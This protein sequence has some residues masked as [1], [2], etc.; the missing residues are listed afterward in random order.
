MM[1]SGV[2]TTIIDVGAK[3]NR[4]LAHINNAIEAIEAIKNTDTDTF[5]DRDELIHDVNLSFGDLDDTRKN[6]IKDNPD[7]VKQYENILRD[8]D[9]VITIHSK[10]TNAMATLKKGKQA[11]EIYNLA[12]G[13]LNVLQDLLSSVSKRTNTVRLEI[14]AKNAKNAKNE[15]SAR[16]GGYHNRC[17]RKRTHRKRSYRKRTHRKRK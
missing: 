10:I 2:A 9:S 17:K 5:T 4:T 16:R 12:L 15:M 6:F 13:Q 8:I 7:M 11:E 1:I 14:Y 3:V